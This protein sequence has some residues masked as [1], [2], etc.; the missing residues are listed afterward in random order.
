MKKVHSYI[1]ALVMAVMFGFANN[2]NAMTEAEVAQYI[3]DTV[4]GSTNFDA[5]TCAD[6]WV[7]G[8]T[9]MT[10]SFDITL[11]CEKNR[12]AKD[13]DLTSD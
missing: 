13:W 11:V 5:R 10:K 6:A 7:H 8:N 9:Y 2:A 1:I 12:I 3:L 4:P